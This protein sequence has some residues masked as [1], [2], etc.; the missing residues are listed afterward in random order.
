MRIIVEK[1]YE[2]M[3]KRA[4][5]EIAKVVNDK[6]N[7]V[8]GLATGSTPEG[9]YKELI[10]LNKE[11][12]VDFSKVTSVNLDEYVGLPGEHSQ[13]YRYFMNTNLFNHI[14]IDKSRTFVPNGLAQDIEEECKRY[15][16]RI[17]ELGGIDIQLLGIG[18]NGHIGFNEPSEFLYMGTHL[19]GLAE[20]TIEA[21]SRFFDSMD[22]VPK[23][24]ITMGL[25]GIMKAKKILLIANGEKKAE[26][27]AKLVEGKIST[28]V[29][30]SILQVHHDVTIIVDEAAA[31]LI[32]K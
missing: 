10:S 30:A 7:C 28:Q 16:E 8:L 20:S 1:N 5:E 23:K 6:P 31:S 13:S 25:G 4:A 17:N 21:N 32:K 11:E 29:P 15:D 12:K 9:L 19:T 27:I 14:N 2:A 26:I 22:E 18:N 3:S 24:A